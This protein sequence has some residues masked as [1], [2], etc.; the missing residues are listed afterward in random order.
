M[1]LDYITP[2]VKEGVTTL[3]LDTFAFF[4]ICKVIRTIKL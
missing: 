1:V 2:F 4:I 3:K